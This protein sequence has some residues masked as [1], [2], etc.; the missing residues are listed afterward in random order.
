MTTMTATATMAVSTNGTSAAQSS[1]PASG[2]MK[3]TKVQ[4]GMSGTMKAS[5]LMQLY[6]NVVLA[7]PTINLPSQVDTATN[8]TVSTDLPKH[9]VTAQNHAKYYINTV[10]P[11]IV[12]TVADI[13]G[14]ANEW[15]S[16]YDKLLVLSHSIDE[17]NHKEMFTEAMQ[18]FQKAIKAKGDSTTP[19]IT[20]LNNLLADIQSDQRNFNQDHGTVE[21]WLA[22]ESGELETLKSEIKAD[23]DAI[24]KDN[25]MI[26]GGAV[27]IVAG[28]LTSIAGVA[29]DVVTGG[30]ATAMV[31][32]GLAVAAG[33]AAMAGIA[34]KDLEKKQKE[35]KSKTIELNADQ[36]LYT[37]VNGIDHTIGNIVG[38]LTDAVSAVESLQHGWNSLHDDFGEIINA[39]ELADPDMPAWLSTQL[40]AANSDWADCHKL[41]QHLQENG[42]LQVTTQ[43]I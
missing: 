33:G 11:L 16:F 6:T 20:A 10:N 23:Q 37:N 21:S 8:T 36:I 41:A 26:A 24:K 32:G 28:V 18:L 14:F 27:M 22:G 9:Q 12:G 5:Y 31:V 19:V 25:A 34:G 38:A 42:T 17:D 39:L 29:A 3:P 43:K 2:K 13:L 1:L 4:D 7:T 30:A 15:N 40:S 35:L